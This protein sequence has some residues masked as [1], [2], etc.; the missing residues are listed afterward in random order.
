M[1]KKHITLSINKDFTL[2][3]FKTIAKE[4]NLFFNECTLTNVQQFKCKMDATYDI[5]YSEEMIHIN[6]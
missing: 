4:K 3:T 2:K 6:K 5:F 1:Q